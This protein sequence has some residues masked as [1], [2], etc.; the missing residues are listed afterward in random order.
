MNRI[1]R[2]AILFFLL[3]TCFIQ[4]AAAAT[5]HVTLDDKRI[6]FDAAPFIE[7]DR[8]L[9]PVRGILESLGYTV[10]WQEHTKTVLALNEDVTI[11]LKLNS[12]KATVNGRSVSVDAP[13]KIKNGRTFVPLRFLAEY[14]GADVSWNGSTS[15]V[16]IYSAEAAAEQKMKRSV[17]Y[18]QTNK[19]QGSG[20]VL[21]SDG[22]IAT[23]YHV[24]E[25]A[26]TAQ[27]IFADGSIYQGETTV[28]GLKPE[29]DIAILRIN[30]SGLTAAG[31]SKGYGKGDAVTAIGSPNGQR[32]R[33]T[34]GK[35]AGY[36]QD[37]ISTT[38]PIGQGS[39]G[40]GLFNSSRKLIGM[41]SSYADGNYFSIPIAKVQQV[42][43]NLSIPLKEIRNYDY[44]APAPQNLRVRYENDGYA[45]VSWSPVYGAE[46]YRIY[47]STS[48]DGNFLPMANTSQGSNKWYWGFPQCFGISRQSKPIYLK[49]TAVVDGVETPASEILKIKAK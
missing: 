3:C 31:T 21:S 41:T 43:R 32:N 40:G 4:P 15:T 7:N 10:H 39:S 22:V 28:I 24:I 20:I 17:V 25:N 27:F 1:F 30:K 18:I 11:S 26:S 2:G 23:N 16:S 12:R 49:V 48:P 33:L 34:T 29:S 9:V 13:A 36:D 45:Y 42:S 8:V 46:Y 5:I 6:S 35:I 14:S 47:R 38:A 19:M 37:I 44:H